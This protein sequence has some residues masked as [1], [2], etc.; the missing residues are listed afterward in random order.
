MGRPLREW[1]KERVVRTSLNVSLSLTGLTICF[2][3]SISGATRRFP[4]HSLHIF[5]IFHMLI[6]F[7]RLHPLGHEINSAFVIV[8]PAAPFLC[9]R[10]AYFSPGFYRPLHLPRQ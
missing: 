1:V 7:T 10:H 8:P 2:M 3:K 5:I 4:L 6:S 9:G